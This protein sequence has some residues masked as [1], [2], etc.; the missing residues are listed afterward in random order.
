MFVRSRERE[1]ERERE[2]EKTWNKRGG[3]KGGNGT[4]PLTNIKLRKKQ[5]SNEGTI[6][7]TSL[8]SE[9]IVKFF[10]IQRMTYSSIRLS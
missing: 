5:K 1:R 9:C 3:G 6:L 2:K 8:T 4:T 7:H 10:Y